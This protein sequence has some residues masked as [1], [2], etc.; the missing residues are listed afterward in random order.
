MNFRG[1]KLLREL[2]LPGP[3]KELL[4]RELA[5]VDL[6]ELYQG[7]KRDVTIMVFD[8]S[9]PID[10]NPLLEKNVRRYQIKR[11]EYSKVFRELTD[12]ILERGVKEE[13]LAYMTHQTYLPEDI[14]FSGRVAILV[15]K[16]GSRSFVID[17]VESLRERDTDFTPTFIYRCPIIDGKPDPTKAE[18]IRKEIDFP[19]K[20][21]GQMIKDVLKIPG[22]PYVDFEVFIAG[23]V[24]FYHDLF[25][26]KE[27]S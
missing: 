24:L 7:A 16:N 27:G 17:A 11:E 14:S 3:K 12:E 9:E 23:D 13:N 8:Y 22:I 4:F 10:Q 21:I 15:E 25:L 19:E 1:I 2:G 26:A 5:E 18:T 6:D 20:H